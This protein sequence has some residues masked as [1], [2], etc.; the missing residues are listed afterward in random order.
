MVQDSSAGERVSSAGYQYDECTPINRSPI[1]R[2][3]PH[4][5]ELCRGRGH[6]D[7]DA[8]EEEESAACPVADLWSLKGGL[9]QDPNM[10]P[11]FLDHTLSHSITHSQHRGGQVTNRAD[12]STNLVEML[13]LVVHAAE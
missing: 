7:P 8:R 13:G 9:S 4:V 5:D 11:V 12:R 2:S 3:P 1:N 10:G 6:D